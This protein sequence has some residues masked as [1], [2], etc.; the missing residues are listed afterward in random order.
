MALV[1]AARTALNA[2]R[3]IG[4]RRAG[5]DPSAQEAEGSVREDL[6][7][8]RTALHEQILRLRI[9]AIAPTPEAPVA[10]LAQAFEDRLLLDDF[11]RAVRRSHQKLLSL[12]PAVPETVVEEARMLGVEGERRALADLDEMD[13]GDLGRR[14]AAWLDELDEALA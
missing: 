10:A 13:L 14:A 8:L 9:R 2:A 11:A 3:A 7:A 12:Y 1:A 4:D 6:S 5:R